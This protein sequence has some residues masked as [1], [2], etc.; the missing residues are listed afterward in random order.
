MGDLI[1]LATKHKR[2]TTM[3]SNSEDMRDKRQ[4]RNLRF[5][6]FILFLF[7]FIALAWPIGS[8]LHISSIKWLL[9]IGIFALVGVS[10]YLKGK[11]FEFKPREL[12][13]DVAETEIKNFIQAQKEKGIVRISDFEIAEKLDLPVDQVNK[14]LE[15][16]EV[17]GI[18]IERKHD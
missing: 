5:N 17:D 10:I 7:L 4:G 11:A 14:L 6:I 9:V 3:G 13:D 18:V 16:L 2:Q 15:K 1:E 12:P 8:V